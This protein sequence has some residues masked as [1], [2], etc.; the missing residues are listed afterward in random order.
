MVIIILIFVTYGDLVPGII[1]YLTKNC[2]ISV[3]PTYLWFK[4]R[5]R[6]EL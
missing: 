6:P 3:N 5:L 2:K 4:S 1:I